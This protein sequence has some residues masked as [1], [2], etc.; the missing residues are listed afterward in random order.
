MFAQN[1]FNALILSGA[2]CCLTAANS[3][4]ADLQLSLSDETTEASYSSANSE[5]S[6]TKVRWL[7]HQDNGDLFT[8]GLYGEGS[9]GKYKARLGGYAY[10]QNLDDNVIDESGYGLAMGGEITAYL[11]PKLSWQTSVHFSPSV[12]SYGDTEDLLDAFT[13]L[14]FNVF[15][16][17]DIVVG[18]RHIELN[19]EGTS[20]GFSIH[21]GAYIGLKISL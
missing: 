9:Q 4:A 5:R 17:T 14:N 12:V 21:E 2:L 13:Q 20:L 3:H 6:S 19:L 18:Y 15:E 7:H 1:R 10:Y 8:A 11:S 16:S